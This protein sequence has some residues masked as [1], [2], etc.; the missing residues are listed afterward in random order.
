MFAQANDVSGIVLQLDNLAA[1]ARAEGDP[2]KATRL[3]AAAATYQL[4]SGTGLGHFLREQEGRLHPRE[5]LDDQQAD[6]A[7]SEGQAMSLEQAVAYALEGSGAE[8]P[9]TGG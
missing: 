1:V 3:F 4:T 9:T 6:T 8:A 2:M 5:G 7:W